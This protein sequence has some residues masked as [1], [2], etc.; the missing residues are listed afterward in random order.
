MGKNKGANLLK[1]I[2]LWV[3][4]WAETP[5]G[6]W[7]LFLLALSESSFFPVPPDILL[8]ALAIAI[9]IKSFRYALICTVGSVTGGAFGYLLGLKLMDSVGMPIIN[10]YNALDHFEQLRMLYNQYDVWVVATAGFT[11]IPY[12][13]ITI[14]AGAAKL[15]FSVFILVSAISR[16]ARFF[17]VALLVFKYGEPIKEFIDKYFNIL[18]V[19]FIGL[20]AGGFILAKFAF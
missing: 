4:H 8:I 5:Y 3:L 7:V 2:Y 17:L 6:P 12:K 14:T 18:S 16:G 11:I 15:D 19:L 10:F 13:I 20:L 9:P 1:K